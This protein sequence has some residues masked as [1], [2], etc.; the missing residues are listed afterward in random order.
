MTSLFNVFDDVT[1][2]NIQHVDMLF[3]LACLPPIFNLVLFSVT[4]GNQSDFFSLYAQNIESVVM[5]LTK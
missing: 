2:Q 1:E 5:E 4:G 3:Y